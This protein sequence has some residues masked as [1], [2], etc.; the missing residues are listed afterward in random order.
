MT[1]KERFPTI[2]AVLE[3]NFYREWYDTEGPT[4]EAQLAR[5]LQGEPAERLEA[6]S[7]EIERFLAS[8]PPLEER[9]AWLAKAYVDVSDDELLEVL[10]EIRRA[11][12]RRPR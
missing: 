11:S 8:P 3:G 10:S 7:V 6:M 12:A 5:L 2:T 1:L 4:L 9:E